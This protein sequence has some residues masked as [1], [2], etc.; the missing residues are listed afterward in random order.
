MAAPQWHAI[1]TALI[2]TASAMTYPPTTPENIIILSGVVGLGIFVDVDH[3]SVRGVRRI[4]KGVKGP[5][6]GW[7]N[8]MHTWWALVAVVVGS[9]TF[10]NW[11]PFLSYA[12]HMLIDG[13]NRS[14]V[15][16]NP[17]TSPLPQTIHCFYPHWATYE[18]GQI[19]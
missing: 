12:V 10:G 14:D 6:P 2:A 1:P 8:W 7:V 4:L 3:V 18:T 16:L 19:I 13:G 9:F 5:L 17:G 11:L 15:A